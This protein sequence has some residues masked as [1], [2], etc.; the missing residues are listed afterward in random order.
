M[1]P[2]P[3]R[4]IKTNEENSPKL[5]KKDLRRRRSVVITERAK[6]LKPLEQRIA[7]VEK[8]IAAHEEDLN[9]LNREMREALQNHNG[10]RIVELSQSIHACQDAIEHLFG[11][12]EKLT[13]TFEAQRMLF[14]EKLEPIE[15]EAT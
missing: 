12:L 7:Q 4:K 3:A 1:S 13:T 8:D 5:N 9:K 15:G 10:K 2:A 6:I 14:Q 11:D